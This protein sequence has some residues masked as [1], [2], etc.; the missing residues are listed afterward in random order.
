MEMLLIINSVGGVT[1]NICV[2]DLPR[3]NSNDTNKKSI[4][5]KAISYSEFWNLDWTV[6]NLKYEK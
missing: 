2:S 3:Y 5:A 4:R 1:I 6:R